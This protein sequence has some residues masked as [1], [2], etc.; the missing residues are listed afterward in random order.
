MLLLLE[1]GY[2]GAGEEEAE[3]G[4]REWEGGKKTLI[5]R[6]GESVWDRGRVAR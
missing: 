6:V 2:L 5:G 4:E 1:L 3:G